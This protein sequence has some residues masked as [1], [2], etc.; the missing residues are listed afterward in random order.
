MGVSLLPILWSLPL[1]GTIK[2]MLTFLTPAISALAVTGFFAIFYFAGVFT[3]SVSSVMI[4]PVFLETCVSIVCLSIAS[5]AFFL[6]NSRRMEIT[7]KNEEAKKEEDNSENEEADENDES[8]DEKDEEA[9]END[10][11]GDEE[12]DE[13]DVGSDG[14]DGTNESEE[15]EVG[16]D[17][18]VSD[19]SSVSAWRE[20]ANF[21]GV[22]NAPPLSE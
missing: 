17:G 18:T 11:S 22:R 7:I 9:N 16:S 4:H 5:V 3:Y 21:D 15:A 8:G 20:T 10:E 12:K 14:E 19:A 13:E 2:L 6:I 1:S